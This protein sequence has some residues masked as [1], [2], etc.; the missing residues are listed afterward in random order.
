MDARG[1]SG[2][3]RPGG[4]PDP[5]AATD[6]GVPGK[7]TQGLLDPDDYYYRRLFTD[8][9]PH[10]HP[11]HDRHHGRGPRSRRSSALFG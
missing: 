8:A 5:V 3:H 2:P 7:T 11:A 10:A 6:P 1:Q 4:T 9:L